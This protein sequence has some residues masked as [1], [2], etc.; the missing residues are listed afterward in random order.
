[1]CF[2]D[3]S[4]LD[5]CDRIRGHGGVSFCVNNKYE[6]YLNPIHDGSDRVVGVKLIFEHPLLILCTYLPC[7][8][9]SLDM[10]QETLDEMGEILIKYNDCPNVVIGGD[11]NASLLRKTSQDKFLNILLT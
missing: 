10:Y 11:M 5:P 4:L 2:D 1:M 9:H 6:Q 7:R 8:G 3:S